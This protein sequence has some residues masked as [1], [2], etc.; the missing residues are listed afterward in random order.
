V[1]PGRLRRSSA[2]TVRPVLLQGEQRQ[3]ARHR[4][5]Q[6]DWASV[7]VAPLVALE[8]G[9]PRS[10][11]IDNLRLRAALLGREPCERPG[12]AQPAPVNKVRGVETLTA[13]QLADL[14][15]LGARVGLVE[16]PLLVLGGEG[17]SPGAV[18]EDLGV[19]RRGPRRF[20]AGSSWCAYVFSP[21]PRLTV[22]ASGVGVSRTLAQRAIRQGARA[23]GDEVA[24]RLSRR[25]GLLWLP[26][27][28]F[29]APEA[30]SGS[31]NAISQRQSRS[32]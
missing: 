3:A 27:R 23:R 29:P 11:G 9:D 17:A 2:I 12:V 19:G 24:E 32:L 20:R 10:E 14:S 21:R 30:F 13:Q 7:E 26:E 4:A 6:G 25:H 1:R 15:G 28:D 8:L 31:E 18:G 16:N 22:I 5:K